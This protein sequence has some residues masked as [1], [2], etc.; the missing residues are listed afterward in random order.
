M[1]KIHKN[2][3]KLKVGDSVKIIESFYCSKELQSGNTGIV[4]EIGFGHVSIILDNGILGDEGAI[5]NFPDHCLRKTNIHKPCIVKQEPSTESQNKQ[6]LSYLHYNL[7][8][9]S[10]IGHNF[11]LFAPIKKLLSW[12]F[13][14]GS[15]FL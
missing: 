11:L 2:M 4:S 9:L 6:I 12:L 7:I 14:W 13:L 15:I 1:V 3:E 8:R 5:W 10:S